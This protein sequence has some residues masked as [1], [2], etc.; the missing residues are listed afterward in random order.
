M[1][2]TPLQQVGYVRLTLS[3]RRVHVVH[4]PISARAAVRFWESVYINNPVP[5]LSE[6]S[7]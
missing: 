5:T 2:V 4:I 1:Q 6:P 7:V 3:A